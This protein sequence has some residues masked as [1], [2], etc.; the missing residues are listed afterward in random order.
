MLINDNGITRKATA[1]EEKKYSIVI[2]LTLDDTLQA[3]N[4]MGVDTND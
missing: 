1:E 4:E 3:L 2:D